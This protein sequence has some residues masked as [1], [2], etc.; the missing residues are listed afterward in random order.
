MTTNTNPVTGCTIQV[1]GQP[2]TGGGYVCTTHSEWASETSCDTGE[3]LARGECG[4]AM[5]EAYD[6]CALD[7]G[8]FRGAK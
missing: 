8:T 7:G 3:R 6:G 2:R 4:H 5:C 1:G